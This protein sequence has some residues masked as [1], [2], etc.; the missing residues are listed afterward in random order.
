MPIDFIK[1]KF[2]SNDIQIASRQQKQLSYFTESK[3]QDDVSQEY[4]EAWAERMYQTDDYFLNFVK[5]VFKKENFLF[6]FRYM[7]FPL[8]SARLV[9]D[10]I[11]K[12]LERVF[13]ADDSFFK[14]EI[15]GE[16]VKQPDSL[17]AQEFNEWM[18]NALLF[19]HNDILVV[20]LYDINSP[21]KSLISIDNVV[22]LDSQN[23]IIKRI[24]YTAQAEVEGV[25]CNGILYIDSER[26]AFFKKGDG[27]KLN[28]IPDLDVPHD[29]GRCPADYISSDAFSTSD[30]I[31]KSIFT[32][33]RE[34][35][36]EYV[37]M[38][39]MQR[40]V[41]PNGAIP[42]VTQLDTGVDD[43]NEDGVGEQGEPMSANR[44]KNQTS[45]VRGDI[46]SYKGK[47]QTGSK[48][49]VPLITKEDGSVD[50][51]LVKNYFNFFYLPT[52][53]LQY[54]DQ[55]VK[56]LKI[57]IISNIIGDHSEGS[58]PEGSKSDS[59]INKVTIVSRQDVLRDL[60]KQ[61]SRV[62]ERSDYNFLAL[63][64]GKE[65]ISNEAFYG[66]DFF[67]ESQ[68]EIY[69]LISSAPNPIEKKSLLIKSARNRNRF[70]KENFSREYIYY[71]LLP[72]ATRSD[73]D[74][75]VSQ[76]Q[77]TTTIFQLQT[78]FSYWLA[79]FESQYGDILTFW[80]TLDGTENEKVVLINSLIEIIIK[81]N[82]D[83]KSSMAS[84]ISRERDIV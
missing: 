32:Y 37:F 84:D 21:Y 3:V 34:E 63:K 7:R 44:L 39:T 14:Y 40:M 18:F 19:R 65:N 71:H 76:N 12:A 28:D 83:E 77:M 30:I 23:S 57:S 82:Y 49:E 27:D 51:E 33:S 61:L 59:E 5:S 64:Y 81:D 73:F 45:V 22:A 43:D 24:A 13:H 55:R 36:E 35:Q 62:R 48:I 11:K 66:S 42:V 56:D 16:L 47:M 25:L 38:K 10:K 67:L 17:A 79:M 70:N 15:K 2:N 8:P 1:G 80:K 4:I 54:L 31:R 50:M 74:I 75:A 6:M 58:T 60:A 78:R 26:Y 52:E 72:Y 68:K 9:N 69:D 53:A 46:D 20:D 29:L 41:D